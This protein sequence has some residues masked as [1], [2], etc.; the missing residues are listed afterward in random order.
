[1]IG[2]WSVCNNPGMAYVT[3][4]QTS[5]SM[6]VTNS[7]ISNQGRVNSMLHYISDEG[8]SVPL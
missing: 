4:T 5:I 2:S 7:T 6:T 8:Q 1:M 3:K